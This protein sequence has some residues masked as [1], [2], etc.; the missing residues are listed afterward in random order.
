MFVFGYS[1]GGYLSFAYGMVTGTALSCSAVLAASA[2]FGGGTTDPQIT[3][4]TRNLAVV[5]Q[6]GTLDG[7][8]AAAMTTE[9]TLQSDSFPDPARGNSRCGT[10][11]DPRRCLGSVRLLPRPV[12]LTIA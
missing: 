5:L 12:A 7:A 11:P 8:Y 6:I 3:A 2:P 4:A 10:R 9:T 1:Q